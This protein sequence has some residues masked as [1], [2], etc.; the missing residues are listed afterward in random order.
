MQCTRSTHTVPAHAH[1]APTPKTQNESEHESDGDDSETT[2]V[3]SM[4]F[5]T[6][7]QASGQRGGP[8]VIVGEGPLLPPG[9]QVGVH[10][11]CCCL[12]LRDARPPHL[13]QPEASAPAAHDL[14]L[15][16]D[17]GEAEATAAG[18]PERLRQQ[19][20]HEEADVFGGAAE[21]H[22][23]QDIFDFLAGQRGPVMT[24]MTSKGGTV[25]TG[26]ATTAHAAPPDSLI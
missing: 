22:G 1:C 26:K 21:G 8:A 16:M 19:L 7:L 25:A 2:R 13:P 15:S 4:R 20:L 12:M 5:G 9:P 23:N 11:D 14:L 18:L 10:H 24:E 17:D 3:Q 6:E